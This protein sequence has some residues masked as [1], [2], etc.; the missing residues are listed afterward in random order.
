MASTTTAVRLLTT[1]EAAVLA[2]LAMN[3][4]RS[5]Y[6]LH[7]MAA[8]AI[9][10]VWAPAKSQLYAVLPRLARDGLASRRRVAQ[11]TRPDKQLYEITQSGRA[12][13]DAWLE[14][15]EPGAEEAFYLRLFVGGLT[16]PEVLVRH[17]EQ[18]RGEA[19]ARL[20]ELRALEATNVRSGNDWFHYLLLR[21]GIDRAEQSVEWADWVLAELREGA[22]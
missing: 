18:F 22:G 8:N 6:D 12:A 2:L 19:Q 5:G 17:V 14:T 7:K 13:L 21:Y 4:E 15:V 1:T 9:G 20:E 16:S 3:G 10:H 11:S